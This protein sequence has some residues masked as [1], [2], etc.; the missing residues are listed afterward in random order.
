MNEFFRIVAVEG[1]KLRRTLA[2]RLAVL[3]PLFIVILQFTIELVRGGEESESSP[4]LNPLMGFGQGI[5]TFWTIVLL[6]FCAAL[7]AALLAA[8]EHHGDNWKHI[9]ALPVP[10]TLLFAAKWMA[11]AGLLSLSSVVLV[12]A[13]CLAAAILQAVKPGWSA[14][15]WPVITVIQRAFFGLCAAGLLLSIQMWI[16]L[17]WRSFIP[18][19]AIGV[20]ALV[21]NIIILPAG[22]FAA[23]LFPWCLPAVAMAPHSPHRVLGVA[24]GL[25]GGVAVGMIACW[26]LSR[27][28]H[29]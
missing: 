29:Q 12:A 15:S 5:L 1:L 17:R 2:F 21:V 27:R 14:A 19:L 7:I 18:G 24:W 3:A 23:N 13:Y 11:A 4:G 25:L 16:S 8:L 22:M 9:L 28:E 10:R 20:V 6:P 26:D